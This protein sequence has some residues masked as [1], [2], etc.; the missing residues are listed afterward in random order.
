MDPGIPVPPNGYGGHERLVYM[1]AKQYKNLGHEIE[2][3]VSPGSEVDG[4]VVHTF[5]KEGF[6]PKKIDASKA[7]LEAWQFL[8]TRRNKYDLIHN[9][10]RLAYLLPILNSPVK[11]LMTYG[12]EISNRNIKYINRL[13]NKEILFTGCSE[14][15][16]SRGRIAGNW[17]VVYNAIDFGKYTLQTAVGENA[18]LVFL[19]RLERIKGCH[20]AIKIAKVTGNKLII[21]GNVSTLSE[22]MAYFR[23]EIEPLIDGAQIS[24]VGQVNDEQKNNLLGKAK[25]LLFP[26]EW[27]EPFGMVMTEAMACGTPVIGFNRGSVPEVIDNGVTGFV[28]DSEEEMIQAVDK[29]MKMDRNLCRSKAESRFDVKVIADH[30]LSLCQ[31]IK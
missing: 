14:D 24:Y 21:A 17:S 2:L 4:C 20:T 9:F 12:R 13:P 18:P 16:V 25:A 11:K 6:P 10:G 19:S 15:L 1:F 22:E 8:W 30:Y 26:I 28:V 29:T 31:S 23:N 7:I 27:N 5:G 3:I